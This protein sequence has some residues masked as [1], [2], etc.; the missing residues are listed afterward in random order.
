MADGK[1]TIETV[2]ES[3]KFQAG[4]SK[5]KSLSKHGAGFI[6]KAFAAVGAGLTGAAGAL[7]RTGVS[8]ESAFAGVK[9]TVDASERE[10]AGFRQ[11]IR[12]MAK[13]MPASA[14]QIAEVAEAAGQLGIKNESLMGFTKTMTMLGDA[15]NLSADE[16]ATQLAR[17][18]NITGMSQNDFDR[19]G[20]TIVDLGNNLATT[21]A[22]ITAMGMRI[23]G[24]GKQVG[25]SEAEILSYSGALSSV[26]VEAEAGGTAFST[27]LSKMN[28]S[29]ASGG[30]KLKQ[31]AD[32]AGMS[33]SQFKSAFEQDAAGAVLD[34]IE[35]LGDIKEHGGSTIKT[36]DEMGLSDIRMRDALLRASG[37]SDVFT[38]AL[39]IGN[40]AWQENKALANE[41]GQRYQTLESKI[42]IFKN[43]IKDIGISIYDSVDTP[44]G[45]VVSSAT[46]A[47]ENLNKAFQR[48]GLKGLAK[49]AGRLLADAVAGLSK[50]APKMLR[51]AGKFVAAFARGL[52]SHKSEII[53]AA[54]NIIR[55]FAG[56]VAELL[57]TAIG[58]TLKNLASVFVSV[59]KVLVTA[60]GGALKFLNTIAP[61]IPAVA[62]L[63]AAFKAVS[64][65]KMFVAALAAATAGET[66]NT[67]STLANTLATK[68]A[69]AQ[70]TFAAIKTVLLTGVTHG[71]TAAEIAAT[72]ATNALKAALT[73]LT[74]PIGL[75]I[76][77]AG[78]L[79]GLMFSLGTSYDM[80]NPEI[81]EACLKTEKL[82]KKIDENTR[83]YRENI[84]ARKDSE[85]DAVAEGATIDLLADKIINLTKK[86]H[87]TTAE[88]RQLKA[89]IDDLNE[90]V[91]E[92]SL[93]YDNQT[94][95]L[96]LTTE[97]IR[98][99]IAARKDEVETEAQLEN[100]KAAYKEQLKAAKDVTAAEENLA[101]AKKKTKA[102]HRKYEDAV[103]S[104]VD[105]SVIQGK[106]RYE[107][108][109]QENEKKAMEA[110]TKARKANDSLEKD[111]AYWA[112]MMDLSGLDKLAEEAKL[113]G[114]KIPKSVK[115]GIKD[116]SYASPVTAEDLKN[117]VNYDALA[118]DNRSK[119]KSL[120]LK[121]PSNIKEGIAAGGS[122][123]VTATKNL[124]K[125]IKFTNLGTDYQ[126]AGKR[127]PAG[128]VKGINAGKIAVPTT[129][130]K[131]KAL[132]KFRYNKGQLTKDGVKVPQFIAK[133]IQSGKLQPQQAVT[134]MNN[135]IK[136]TTAVQKAGLAGKKI[137]AGLAKQ[138][139]SGDISVK[140]AVD[141]LAGTAGKG[142]GKAADKAKK[143]ASK[144][145]KSVPA[146]FKDAV[147]RALRAISGKADAFSPAGKQLAFGTAQG[148]SDGS[149][150]VAA[151]C[152]KM[153]SNALT[154]AK[155]EA[156]SHSPSRK[157]RDKIGRMM[158][159]GVAVG[160]KLERRG[161][162]YAMRG[163]ICDTLKRAKKVAGNYGAVGSA[164]T[165]SFGKTLD[166]RK[167]AVV[168]VVNR[169]LDNALKLAK[170]KSRTKITKA[171]EKRIRK[172]SNK[173]KKS[174]SSALTKSTNKAKSHAEKRI[175]KLSE[176]YQNSYD[177]II[178]DRKALKEKMAD[179]G[180]LM[181]D[182]D[183]NGLTEISSTANL[184]RALKKNLKILTQYAEGLKKVR[185]AQL[186]KSLVDEIIGMD[187]ATAAKYTRRLFRMSTQERAKYI[188]D[189]LKQQKTVAD[190]K[191]AQQKN[192]AISQMKADVSALQKYSS[193]LKIWKRRLPKSLMSKILDMD[194]EKA[195]EFMGMLGSMSAKELQTYKTLWNK[196]QALAHSTSNAFYAKELANLKKSYNK[197]I[198]TELGKL[199]K[200]VKAIGA[201]TMRAFAAGAKSQTRHVSGTLRGIVN[202]AV[203][204][205][206][207]SLK[208]H[209]PSRV[210]KDIGAD[211]IR[212]SEIGI[213]RAAPA[214][215]K[216]AAETAN[217]FA[218]KFAAAR[219][220][221]LIASSNSLQTAVKMK[222]SDIPI[223]TRVVNSQQKSIEEEG[224]TG[225]PILELHTH[226]D[227]DGRE[228]A[229]TTAPYTDTALGE[230]LRF[231]T[232]GG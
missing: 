178:S 35:G 198:K 190:I 175:K 102:A 64:F 227:L 67:A 32:V 155:K 213:K 52:A 166:K 142:T 109:A 51:L 38:D 18:A 91:P 131:L 197:A 74:G 19:L 150:A 145:Q 61:L 79:A 84:E 148:V 41:A 204:A 55:A 174:F 82:S 81:E 125:L 92:L 208:I 112:R 98:R 5:I 162:N 16:A 184:K 94:G 69:G 199:R 146:S 164:F 182:M 167:T 87:K 210:F 28:L 7:V 169:S 73:F 101:D 191:K 43:T 76:S 27:L 154:A 97:A 158:G 89:M 160:I 80:V 193:N 12:D 149:G 88:K 50:A 78:V 220:A 20:S 37:A 168:K 200:E 96:N 180:D 42:G 218:A 15:T 189:Y 140:R 126:K 228:I 224:Y 65:I 11:G 86:E 153:V 114:G 46:K 221:G 177:K 53:S 100:Y 176:A 121:I 143:G 192:S 226:V 39:K 40:S 205:A 62:G 222:M 225:K 124:Q 118:A 23:A 206:K 181:P 179:F 209:S 77:A 60:A 71:M 49:E 57:P 194:V 217:N 105:R 229:K 195:N 170:K 196:Q 99:K 17:L 152:R 54:G 3:K 122:Q 45:K 212:G 207:S 95:K 223:T 13:E 44:L 108:K 163:L 171:T 66:A 58:N 75:V 129:M 103:K 110:L 1:V 34:F 123:A 47:A 185:T 107:A 133:G 188:K 201:N 132:V 56:A 173:I 48:K 25:L 202:A 214:L 135:Y 24:A 139:A 22:D 156:D 63:L 137:P 104:G 186:P 128:I 157:F 116:G 215:Y 138:V 211:T 90:A 144:V 230:I 33:S 29:V 117:L 119:F 30:D 106:I 36:L 130:N 231:K 216:Q 6:G 219:D 83:S 59:G 161:V 127:I 2:L 93:A 172:A 111:K 8:F 85:S 4:L 10:L 9:K 26:G 141:K 120:G 68:A 14:E 134:Q 159:R 203:R 31:F 21:E 72:V 187:V 147:T 113:K 232:R 151:A 183:L 70:K 115:A 136:F 165:D